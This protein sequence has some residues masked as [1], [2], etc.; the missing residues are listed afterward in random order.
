M[1]I[2]GLGFSFAD[3]MQVAAIALSGE[4]LGA[5]LKQRAKDYGAICQHIGFAISVILAAL[6]FFFGK[7]F[8]GLYFDEPH[9]IEMGVMISRFTMVVVLLQISQVIYSGCL[10]A[11]GDVKYVLIAAL[12]SVTT[13]RTL[14]TVLLVLVFP[15]GLAGVW[16]GVLSD[17]GTRFLLMRRRFRP[18]KWVD[19]KI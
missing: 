5:G 6:L 16:L 18:G 13:I 15:M 19:M 12:I 3:G 1:N 4:A 7:W 9:I 14:V 10:R 2:L 8:Y 17:Q 11:A